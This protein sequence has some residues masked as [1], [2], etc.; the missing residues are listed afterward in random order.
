M[1]SL[2][3]QLIHSPD[4]DDITENPAYPLPQCSGLKGTT[5]FTVVLSV[6]MEVIGGK[7]IFL[8]YPEGRPFPGMGTP[9]LE[10]HLN[11]SRPKSR[12]SF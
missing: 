2:R 1:T 5:S 9:S 12:Q 8:Y 6:H 7:W 11:F 10:I 4:T 3:M